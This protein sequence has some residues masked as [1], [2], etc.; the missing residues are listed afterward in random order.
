ME[1]NPESKSVIPPKDKKNEIAEA[2]IMFDSLLK[3]QSS[4]DSN[5]VHK[6]KYIRYGSIA[7]LA[8]IILLSLYLAVNFYTKSTDL[9]KDTPKEAQTDDGTFNAQF[10]IEKNRKLEGKIAKNLSNTG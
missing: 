3:E 1:N 6:I 2:D 5:A 10:Y 4:Q 8:V 9:G 7:F